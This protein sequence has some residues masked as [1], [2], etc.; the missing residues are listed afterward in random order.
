MK[1]RIALIAAVAA[2]S[3]CTYAQ[4]AAAP[5]LSVSATF[6]WESKYVFRGVQLA[7]EI[8]T[9]SVDVSYGGA[10]VGI[11]A[12]MP[13]DHVASSSSE[14]GYLNEIDFYAGYGMNLT[15]ILSI[16][17]GATY[18]SYPS[19]QEELFGS[20]NTLEGYAGIAAEVLLSPAVYAYY[21]FDLEISTFEGSIG[22]SFALAE[23]VSLDLG[24]Y[25]GIAILNPEDPEE[26]EEEADDSSVY[27]GATADISYAIRETSSLT[28]GVRWAGNSVDD[29]FFSDFE[30]KFP[31][32]GV[33]PDLDDA[34]FWY[35]FSF[36]TGF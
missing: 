9:P 11:W 26:G 31:A 32:E 33:T 7:E 5:E 16:D 13:M 1:N 12:A 14:D 2:G 17:V 24:A 15:D 23:N 21:D 18:Y 10:Y 8:L 27:Y 25:V 36:S 30:D 29:S 28:F 19:V 20:V 22:H 3:I 4:D 6:G 34:A 35:G